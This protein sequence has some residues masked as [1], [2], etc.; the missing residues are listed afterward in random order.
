MID[1]IFMIQD[2]HNSQCDFQHASE[3]NRFGVFIQT[4]K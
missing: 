3:K 4:E 2:K 1:R